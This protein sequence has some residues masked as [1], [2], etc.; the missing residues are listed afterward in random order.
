[1]TAQQDVAH[2]KP[3]KKA[4]L[5]DFF[6]HYINPTSPTRAKLVLY[7]IAQAKSDVSTKQISD[8]VKTLDLDSTSSAQVATDLQAKLSTAG[9]DQ[10][11]EIEGLTDYLLHDLK[12][13]EDKIDAAVEAWRSIHTVN[14]NT[15]GLH[16]DATPPSANGTSPILITD[17]RAFKA[18]MTVTRGAVAVKDLS[19]HEELDPKL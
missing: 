2:I 14:G 5:I 18:G 9:H 17:V 8:L 1:M 19:E 10:E 4:D 11:K 6:Q 7:M 3:L 12:V 16:E 13:A 15:N